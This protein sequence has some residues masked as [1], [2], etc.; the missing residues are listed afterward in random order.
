[1]DSIEKEKLAKQRFTVL[2]LSRFGAVLFVGLGIA[3][4]GGR[5]VPEVA[6][7][8]GYAFLLV[9]AINFFLMPIILKKIWVKQDSDKG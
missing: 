2:S 3:N 6:P 5:F 8:L 1:M 4:V 9:G 7:V